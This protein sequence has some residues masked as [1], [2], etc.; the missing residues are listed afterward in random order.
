MWLSKRSRSAQVAS[1][2]MG[3]LLLTAC[4]SAAPNREPVVAITADA[5]HAPT[6]ITVWT[7][8]HLPKEVAAFQSAFTD[9]KKQHPWLTVN[10]VPN[11]DDAAFAKAVAAGNPPDVFISAGPDNVGKFCH[12][13]TVSPLDEYLSA[14]GI[15]VAATFPA[16]ATVYTKYEGKTCA[17]PLLTDVQALYYNKKLFAKA[18]IASPP[19]TL[20]ELTEDAKK[21]TVRNPDGSIKTFGFVPRSDYYLNASMYDTSVTGAPI[22]DAQGKSALGSDP[23]WKEVLQWDANL[24]DYYGRDQVQRFVGTYNAHTDDARNAFI[25]GAVAME[26]SG[27]WHVGENAEFAPNLDYGVAPMPILDSAGSEFYGAGLSAGTVIYLPAGATHQSEAFFAAQKL[28][29]D[30]TFLTTLAD[31]VSNIPT[32]NAALQAWSKKD[33]PHWAAFIAIF[34]HPKSDWYPPTPAGSEA[35]KPFSTFVQQWESGKATDLTA[36]LNEAAAKTDTIVA[37]AQ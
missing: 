29:T 32:T 27:E 7:F 21:L 19:R 5:N 4:T 12:D 10:F 34:K 23:R 25:T 6:T 26:Y 11:K 18:G 2:V 8:N 9:L 22:F 30:T 35:Q 24:L 28:A 37:Q 13:G 31:A 33:D 15:D 20:S 14:S 17:L 36:G 3:G 16:A 1:L